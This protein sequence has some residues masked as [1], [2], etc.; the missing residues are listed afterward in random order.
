MFQ[1]NAIFGG[2]NR[3][4]E[5]VGT[6][7]ERSL[8]RGTASPAA[9]GLVI[10][11]LQGIRD[12]DTFKNSRPGVM[13]VVEQ[14]A[15]PVGGAWG[16]VRCGGIKRV[17][18]F[19]EAFKPCRIGMA[20]DARE[21]AGDGID[22]ESGRKLAAGK[23]EV[24]HGELAIAEKVW[25]ALID[26]LVAPAKKDD[27]VKC[28]QLASDGLCEARATGGKQDDGFPGRIAVR[29]GRD[30]ERRTTLKE[31]PGLENHALAPA[32]GAVIDRTMPVVGELTQVMKVCGKLAVAQ[33]PMQDAVAKGTLEEVG[34]EGNDIEAHDDGHCRA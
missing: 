31:R 26:T 12:R 24:A 22:D 18:P 4:F 25:N 32:E 29:F 14:T 3:V 15:G 34:K 23:N 21:Q 16:A 7:P 8:E 9:H 27:A 20:E 17:V 33:S 13:R 5:E 6:I 30:A 1:K 11:V 19:A 28:R 2:E 10:P